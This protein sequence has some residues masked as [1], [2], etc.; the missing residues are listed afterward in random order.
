MIFMLIAEN[1]EAEPLI[2]NA[3]TDVLLDTQPAYTSEIIPP[4]KV[5]DLWD[6][7]RTAKLDDLE[8][9]K[10]EYKVCDI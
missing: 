2:E 1:L 7:I 3:Y 9:L 10:K 5:E 8:G 6:Y 4:I